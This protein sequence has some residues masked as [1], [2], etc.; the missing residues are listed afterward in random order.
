VEDDQTLT[1]N[2]ARRGAGGRK[3]ALPWWVG[4]PREATLNLLASPHRLRRMLRRIRRPRATYDLAQGTKRALDYWTKREALF[5]KQFFQDKAILEIGS[6]PTFGL[7]LCALAAGAR[8]VANVEINGDRV[9]YDRRL[10]EAILAALAERGYPHVA[11]A[12]Q[13]LRWAE[14]RATPDGDTLVTRY[15]TNARGLEFPSETFD[16][17]FSIA[18]L[19]HVHRPDLGSVLAEVHRVLRPGGLTSHRVDTRDHYQRHTENPL[20]FLRY[21][22]WLYMLMYSNRESF[23]NRYRLS[24][25]I[26]LFSAAG[27][28][29]VRVREVARYD[30]DATWQSFS[31]HVHR[32]FAGYSPEDLRVVSF[33]IEG[34][35]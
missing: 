31:P 27:F 32:S 26:R 21:P 22:E 8:R 17:V 10:Y 9:V 33:L 18:A 6:G 28:H 3:S 12:R 15:G 7:A 11:R 25:F 5:G 19:E 14:D 24:D 1:L 35:R 2:G 34:E 30:D 13:A 16:F 23:S 4:V 20:Q 29:D